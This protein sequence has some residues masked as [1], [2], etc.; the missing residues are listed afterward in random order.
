M[1]QRGVKGG[2]PSRTEEAETGSLGK[3]REGLPEIGIHSF[4]QQVSSA[5]KVERPQ[6]GAAFGI[7]LDS[8]L[9]GRQRRPGRTRSFSGNWTHA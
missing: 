6:F 3:L 4:N 7:Q 2:A 5:K 9:I 8:L 1:S